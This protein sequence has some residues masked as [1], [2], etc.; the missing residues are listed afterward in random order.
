M[1]KRLLFYGLFLI[2][3]YLILLTVPYQPNSDNKQP[4][5]FDIRAWNGSYILYNKEKGHAPSQFSD[6]VEFIRLKKP[7]YLPLTI[8]PQEVG[9]ISYGPDRTAKVR[10]KGSWPWSQAR[11]WCV[12]KLLPKN[13][14]PVQ[15]GYYLNKDNKFYV[16]AFCAFPE[17]F[18]ELNQNYVSFGLTQPEASN[19]FPSNKN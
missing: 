2:G 5:F 18:L 13:E 4:S 7:E 15:N 11:Y 14:Q 6:L 16:N 10:Y 1:K 17:S 19:L 3:G 12:L 9:S 8:P